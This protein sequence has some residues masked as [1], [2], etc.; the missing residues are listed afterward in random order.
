M[1]M[2]VSNVAEKF[3]LKEGNESTITVNVVSTM[4]LVLLLFAVLR[5]SAETWEILPVI[6]VVSTGMHSWTKF[7]ERKMGNISVTL[8]DEKKAR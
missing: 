4:L 3:E 5:R 1:V 6:T 7:P 8:N 2:N